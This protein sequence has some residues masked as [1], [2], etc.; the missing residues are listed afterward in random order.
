MVLNIIGLNQFNVQ[1]LEPN[2]RQ[3][4]P[5]NFTFKC[6]QFF[7][8]GQLKGGPMVGS[9]NIAFVVPVLWEWLAIEWIADAIVMA[10][11]DS[12]GLISLITE[13][14]NQAANF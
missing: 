10:D 5:I 3:K 12:N 8:L 9:T 7:A 13:C 1:W 14:Q 2:Y 11:F 4:L 6:Q